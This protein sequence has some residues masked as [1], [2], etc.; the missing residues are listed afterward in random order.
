M[1]L[2]PFDKESIYKCI[3]TEFLFNNFFSYFLYLTV[4]TARMVLPTG[5]NNVFFL[6]KCFHYFLKCINILVKLFN[7]ILDRATTKM[8]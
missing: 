5:E 4:K 3:G 7:T 6:K 2:F 8:Y 1:Y